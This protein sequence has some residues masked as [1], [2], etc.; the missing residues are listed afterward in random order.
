MLFIFSITVLIRHLWQVKT[1]VFLHRCLI[2]AILLVI[3]LNILNCKHKQKPHY[4]FQIHHIEND[5]VPAMP[6]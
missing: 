3:N 1:A 4:F 5:L 6:R 2:C